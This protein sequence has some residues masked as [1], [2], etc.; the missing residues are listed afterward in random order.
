MP[1][2]T[3]SKPTLA[4]YGLTEGAWRKMLDAQGGKCYICEKEPKKGRLCIDHFHTPGWKKLPPE[5]RVMWV[6]GLLC[7][8]C[9]NRF[10]SRGIDVKKSKRIVEYLEAFE[11]KVQENEAKSMPASVLK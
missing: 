5:C 9:N 1:V 8:Y 2:Q 3:P 6:R 7:W 11:K 10:L 4:R